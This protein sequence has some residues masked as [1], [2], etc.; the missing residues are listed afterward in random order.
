[1]ATANEILNFNFP[2]VALQEAAKNTFP[3]TLVQLSELR[4][5][6][7]NKITDA[8]GE[9]SFKFD[10]DSLY[11]QVYKKFHDSI[12]SNT[13]QL[14]SINNFDKRELKTLSYCLDYSESNKA[15]P[16]I[17]TEAHLN[18]ALNT[19]QKNWKDSFLF[20]LIR[21]YLKNWES[22]HIDSLKKL[23][24]FIIIKLKQYDGGRT[25]LKSFQTNIKFFDIKNGDVIL[26]SELALRNKN[27]NHA[28]KHLSLPENWFA[29]PYFS[30]V[31]IAY[32]EKRKTEI[33]TFVEDLNNALS[34]HNSSIS[35]K[36][37]VSKLIIQANTTDFSILQ[38]KIKSIAFKLVGDPGNAANWIAFEIATETEKEDLR[39]ARIILNEWITR[40]FI[41]VFFEKCINDS[42]R[43]RFWLKYAKEITQFRVVGSTYVKQLLMTDNRINEYVSPR[44]SKTNSSRDGN[45]ALMFVMR[46]YL[47]VEF[48][49]D[50]AFYVYKIS[51][52]LAPSIEKEFFYSTDDLK[53]THYRQLIYRSGNTV[54]EI[55]EEGKLP[56]RDGDRSWEEVASYWVKEK[57]GINV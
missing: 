57:L 26:G 53:L 51:N 38:D 36:R 54:N 9:T 41:N 37:L 8:V 44:F 55:N 5:S 50:G 19:L 15:F 40:Q 21:C 6:K 27:I 52:Q 34:E 24:E 2:Y 17:A 12:S 30:K 10:G 29:Y 20:G 45:A 1:M 42:R 25:I 14:I 11:P 31:I 43:K 13:Y 7:L 35:N 39:K 4:I 32:Y 47:F 22:K 16:I 46:Q 48:S 3:E 28:T 23:Y 49:D 56:H 18:I 33:S